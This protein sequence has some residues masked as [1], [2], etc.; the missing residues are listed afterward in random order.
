MASLR[1]IFEVTVLIAILCSVVVLFS[2]PIVV[3][4]TAVSLDS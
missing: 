3:F 1:E 4:Y 2:G